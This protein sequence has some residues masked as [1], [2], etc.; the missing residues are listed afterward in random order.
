M[1]P[2]KQPSAEAKFEWFSCNEFSFNK[3][4]KHSAGLWAS[5]SLGRIRGRPESTI[6]AMRCY[7][8]GSWHHTLENNPIVTAKLW[9]TFTKS[10]MLQQVKGNNNSVRQ[11]RNLPCPKISIFLAHVSTEQHTTSEILS[12]FYRSHTS[13]NSINVV[14][15]KL[16]SNEARRKLKILAFFCHSYSLH[17][18]CNSLCRAA[19][20]CVP[21][22]LT[23]INFQHFVTAHIILSQPEH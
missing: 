17:Q 3:P 6:S 15:Y 23:S 19:L 2:F 4:D 14:N 1:I 20:F 22:V 21:S 5:G 9:M 7:L 13:W 10:H 12:E 16:W 18:A 8:T 11:G